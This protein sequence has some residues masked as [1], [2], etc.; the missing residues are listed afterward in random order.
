MW[1]GV[2]VGCV[3]YGLGWEEQNLRWKT[4]RFFDKFNASLN[5]R[6]VIG[7][8]NFREAIQL[9]IQFI[10]RKNILCVFSC[11]GTLRLSS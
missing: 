4:M 5:D 1:G 9:H 10:G 6:T 11:S 7:G 3:G 8:T 2:G